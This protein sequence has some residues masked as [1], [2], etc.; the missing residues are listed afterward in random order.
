MIDVALQTEEVGVREF[1]VGTKT[2]CLDHTGEELSPK[3]T[4]EA[5]NFPCYTLK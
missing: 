3:L 5:Q 4:S 2:H 1:S